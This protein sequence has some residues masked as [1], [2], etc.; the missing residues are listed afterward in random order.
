MREQGSQVPLPS[1]TTPPIRNLRSRKAYMFMPETS[2]LRL[3][4]AGPDFRLAENLCHGF[5]VFGLDQRDLAFAVVLRSIVVARKAVPRDGLDLR[6]GSQRRPPLADE[7]RSIPLCPGAETAPS[8][9]PV[10]YPDSSSQNLFAT[11]DTEG[12]E[13]N[14]R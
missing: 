6:H 1:R 3:Y 11:E 14:N 10:R 7:F 4:P 2:R 5:Q 9:S 12:T 8:V 13:E